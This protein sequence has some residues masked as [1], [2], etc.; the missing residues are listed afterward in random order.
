MKL[1]SAWPTTL[2]LCLSFFQ[3]YLFSD[4][5]L[6]HWKGIASTLVA[7]Q[8]HRDWCRWKG[9]AKKINIASFTGT[10]NQD[11]YCAPQKKFC[12]SLTS[13]GEKVNVISDESPRSW[14][15]SFANL[16]DKCEKLKEREWVYLTS[17]QQKWNWPYLRNTF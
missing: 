8:S 6:F 3:K 2:Y 10:Q 15:K 17:T 7:L 1:G 14:F 16:T 5:F 4:D 12:V 9:F 13:H 11:K